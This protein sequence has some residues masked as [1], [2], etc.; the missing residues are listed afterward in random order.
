M[1]K[2]I[3]GTPGLW[4]APNSELAPPGSLKQAR[5]TMVRR[6]GVIEKLRPGRQLYT[7]A[8]TGYDPVTNKIESLVYFDGK[9][10]TL[11]TDN[12]LRYDGNSG[13]VLGWATIAGPFSGANWCPLPG[14]YDSKSLRTAEA[15]NNLYLETSAGVVKI[16]SAAGATAVGIRAGVPRSLD[17]ELSLVSGTLLANTQS[18]A[19]RAVFGI[20]DDNSNLLLGAPSGRAV[21][22]AT[23]AQNV[24]VKVWIPKNIVGAS[25]G[26]SYFVQLYRTSIQLTA[27]VDPGEEMQLVYQ[28]F[29]TSTDISNKFITLTDLA[30]DAIRGASLYSSPS[31]DGIAQANYQPPVARDMALFK[32]SMFYG[33]TKQREQIRVQLLGVSK[34]L[35]T[36]SAVGNAGPYTFSGSPDL[37]GISPA[38]RLSVVGCTN[39]ANNGDFAIVSVDNVAKTITTANGS[40]VIETPPATA[41]GFPSQLTIDGIDYYGSISGAAENPATGLYKVATGNAISGTGTPQQDIKTTCESLVRVV[42]QRN[43]SVSGSPVVGYYES[44]PDDGAGKMLFENVELDASSPGSQFGI[45]ASGLLFRSL[46]NPVIAGGGNLSSADTAPNRLYISKAGQPEHVPLANYFDIGSK[47]AAIL[48]IVPLREAMLVFKQDGLFRVTGDGAGN[49]A[50]SAFDPAVRLILS[51]GV[52]TCANK[53]Y[54]ATARGILQISESNVNPISGPVANI[55]SASIEPVLANPNATTGSAIRLS[56]SELDSLVYCYF[57]DGRCLIYSAAT[58]VWSEADASSSDFWSFP[59]TPANGA[60]AR[61]RTGVFVEQLYE[62]TDSAVLGVIGAGSPIPDHRYRLKVTAVNA[63]AKQ[64]TVSAAGDIPGG[65]V[66]GLLVLENDAAATSRKIYRVTAVAGSVLTL[67][68]YKGESDTFSF[69]TTVSGL[70]NPL[71]ALV[72]FAATV[73]W[74][75]FTAGDDGAM[76]RFTEAGVLLDGASTMTTCSMSMSTEATIASTTASATP[77]NSPLPTGIQTQTL[78]RSLVPG[79]MQH[80]RRLGVVFQHNTPSEIVLIRGVSYQFEPLDAREV[81]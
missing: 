48:R 59:A 67:A 32:G 46:F 18:V 69:V 79:T 65:L 56:A 14:L 52:T 34:N 22:T 75:D 25:N 50:V 45:G 23:G 72:P 24:S 4:T 29:L 74:R 49:F 78:V 36:I 43:Y 61:G 20:L 60:L 77:T 10:L 41:R 6:Y 62:A 9:Y 39:S 54:A 38:T 21:V 47:R 27:G 66:I 40:S 19:Y 15:N 71:Y 17:V 26:T 8:E 35:L 37:S 73:E 13:G 76:C 63:G 30:A 68:L 81:S 57:G 16:A 3:N 31:Q 80:A 42:N 7:A 33:N 55:A 2:T 1:R 5:N 64:I 28:A 70:F 58:S 51:D 53:A 12:T 11:S 44:G